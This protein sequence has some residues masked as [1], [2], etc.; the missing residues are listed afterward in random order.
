M[1]FRPPLR[2]AF[3]RFRI[4]FAN[5]ALAFVL[6]LSAGG[7]RADDVVYN[8]DFFR[9]RTEIDKVT[10]GDTITIGEEK[11]EVV[12]RFTRGGEGDAFMVRGSDGRA[13]IL[14]IP[15]VP[16]VKEALLLEAMH[17][18]GVKGVPQ[19]I[20]Q[21]RRGHYLIKEM[22]E[23][24]PLWDML[25]KYP[26]PTHRERLFAAAWVVDLVRELRA[27]GYR[28]AD[29]RSPN[30]VIDWDRR[31]AVWIDPYNAA[32]AA[33]DELRV[34][35]K[36]A[37]METGRLYPLD[38]IP[39]LIGEGDETFWML[40]ALEDHRRNWPHAKLGPL[41]GKNG[42][43][44]PEWITHYMLYGK[45]DVFGSAKGALF[46]RNRPNGIHVRVRPLLP[47]DQERVREMLVKRLRM[48][49]PMRG[50]SYR[51]W[52]D[53]VAA[54]LQHPL[55]DR[56]DLVGDSLER[57]PVEDARAVLRAWKLRPEAA[58]P[59]P[60]VTR[61]SAYL[62]LEPRAS[63]LFE[64]IDVAKMFWG[65]EQV[66]ML[67]KIEPD[68]GAWNE[69]GKRTIRELRE[70]KDAIASAMVE[71]DAG[72]LVRVLTSS[73]AGSY[74]KEVVAWIV[75]WRE[76]D[77]PDAG[78]AREIVKELRAYSSELLKSG[79]RERIRKWLRFAMEK[80]LYVAFDESM[81]EVILKSKCC[82]GLI[83]QHVSMF[84][85][86][87]RNVPG[88]EERLV[89]ESDLDSAVRQ[90]LE[91]NEGDTSRWET[92]EVKAERKGASHGTCIRDN[93]GAIPLSAAPTRKP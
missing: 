33:P 85:Y 50:E 54:A 76:K 2:S 47:K 4:E 82:D 11:Y 60:P 93:V 20:E 34:P 16:Q 80:R 53:G 56:W 74:D 7:A 83:A 21:E 23:G 38:G 44:S 70:A 88:W 9:W 1:G 31:R 89:A 59:K 10:A 92:P 46:D 25:K 12:Q 55:F 61:H 8:G 73:E 29:L 63:D 65:D 67:K 64:D 79:D 71:P 57:I 15:H 14:K 19:V 41:L 5:A 42:F 35:A 81:S 28:A 17:K 90:F 30:I 75:R 87:L 18:Q 77:G 51:D 24:E 6:L 3:S 62:A 86:L 27:H 58:G 84:R 36:V 40:A 52:Q 13:R 66:D 91:P 78:F 26:P 45:A 72:K 48:K 49:G 32:R 37:P 43:L 39:P 69:A 68:G 22:I